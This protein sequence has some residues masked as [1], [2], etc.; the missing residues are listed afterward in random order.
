[1][2]ELKSFVQLRSYDH[3]RGDLSHDLGL[4]A[5]TLRSYCDRATF[6]KHVGI[7]ALFSCALSQ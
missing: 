6:T 1:M 4:S 3:S 2:E 5:Y 7:L